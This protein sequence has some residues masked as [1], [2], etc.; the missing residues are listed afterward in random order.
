MYDVVYEEKLLTSIH[1]HM[2]QNCANVFTVCIL[3]WKEAVISL[4]QNT[5]RFFLIL[6]LC[7]HVAQC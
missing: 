1:D 6:V 4:G 7:D 2:F 5:S 3:L